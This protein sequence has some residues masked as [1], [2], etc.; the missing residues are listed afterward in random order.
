M[1]NKYIVSARYSNGNLQ[2]YGESADLCTKYE[3]AG[4]NNQKQ[5][6]SANALNRSDLFWS[7]YF[8]LSGVLENITAIYFL[9]ICKIYQEYDKFILE[10]I[11]NPNL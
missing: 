4:P 6:D 9:Q 3:N 10:I 8:L 7:L 1:N 5:P 2:R 11:G